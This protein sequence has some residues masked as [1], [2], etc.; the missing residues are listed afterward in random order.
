[1]SVICTFTE[2]ARAESPTA[3]RTQ[4]A[5]TNSRGNLRRVDRPNLKGDD[6]VSDKSYKCNSTPDQSDRYSSTPERS[7]RFSSTPDRNVKSTSE[8]THRTEI[9]NKEVK[10]RYRNVGMRRQPNNER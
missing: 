6:L 2:T 8:L 10:E 4:P 5:W 9:E 7:Y 1:M 3:F